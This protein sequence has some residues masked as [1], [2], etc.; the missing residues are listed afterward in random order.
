MAT[1]DI[2][3]LK[4][5]KEVKEMYKFICD[6]EDQI[7]VVLPKLYARKSK[8]ALV[9]IQNKSNKLKYYSP[10]TYYNLK[11]EGE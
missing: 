7:M 2:E 9:K 1:D 3:T 6:K 5:E 4:T 11:D 10:E 8:K